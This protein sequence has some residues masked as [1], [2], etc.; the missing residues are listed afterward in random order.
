MKIREEQTVNEMKMK[1]LV[2]V[3]N[4]IWRIEGKNELIEYFCN[5]AIVDVFSW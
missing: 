4:R 2:K 3:Q 1:E 5:Q